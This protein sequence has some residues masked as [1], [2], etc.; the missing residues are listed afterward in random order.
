MDLATYAAFL[1]SYAGSTGLQ[2][3]IQRMLMDVCDSE[4]LV[5]KNYVSL[6]I[7]DRI[8]FCPD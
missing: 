2:K 1:S 6:R 3:K 5:L 4:M 7:A 8:S